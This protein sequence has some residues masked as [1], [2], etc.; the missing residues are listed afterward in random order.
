MHEMHRTSQTKV[1]SKQLPIHAAVHMQLACLH[2]RRLDAHSR[3]MVTT[4][5]EH[6][7]VMFVLFLHV[8]WSTIQL[9][10]D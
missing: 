5:T 1:D 3:F 2:S 10:Y 4:I 9:W 6:T 7:R 8:E